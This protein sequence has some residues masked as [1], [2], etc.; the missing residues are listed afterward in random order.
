MAQP[1]GAQELPV[2]R[3]PA[4]CPQLTSLR[5]FAAAVVVLYHY[6]AEVVPNGPPFLKNLFMH[7]FVGVTVFFVLSGYIL[8]LNYLERF[9]NKTTNVKDF[10][11]ARLAR[12]YPLYIVMLLAVS[13]YVLLNPAKFPNGQE[14]INLREN[15]VSATLMYVLGAESHWPMSV[16]RLPLPSWSIST[17][18]F[19]YA[20]FPL[21]AYIV[22]RLSRTA[23]AVGI[24]VVSLYTVLHTWGF[25]AG[26]HNQPLLFLSPEEV[27]KFSG[28][29]YNS[30]FA[31]IHSNWPLFAT[32]MLAYKLF[33]IEFS[34]AAKR[35]LGIGCAVVLAVS[36]LIFATMDGVKVEEFIFPSKNLLPI[37]MCI[38]LVAWLH[39]GTGKVHTWLGN[40][41]LVLLGEISFALY[42]VHSPL[43]LMGRF[44]L[45]RPLGIPETSPLFYIPMW[46]L[47]LLC[48][49][50][51][52]KWVEVPA[53][54]AVLKAWK[55]SKSA[56]VTTTG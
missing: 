24:G 2:T 17:E 7:G 37:P 6:H 55:N 25:Y 11:V 53:R 34:Q 13:P 45:A 49:W 8:S 32:G 20:L 1:G 52:W 39:K 31:G 27:H 12:I 29:F 18:F 51:A 35:L 54:R 4:F 47:S 21:F 41:T 30:Y 9:K 43:R 38:L 33:D 16:G 48:A 42:L 22:S 5:F 10:W 19:F 40:K 15:P 26:A 56:P 36:L 23:C 50:L 46:G 14:I 3:T 44:F 28:W